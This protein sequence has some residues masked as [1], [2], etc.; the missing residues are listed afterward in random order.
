MSLRPITLELRDL[1]L[2]SYSGRV[3]VVEDNIH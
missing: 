1:I 2:L 3:E